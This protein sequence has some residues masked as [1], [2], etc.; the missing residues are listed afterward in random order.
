M[1]CHLAP[2]QVGSVDYEP[3]GG[4]MKVGPQGDQFG[5]FV[6]ANFRD[7]AL[8][9]FDGLA[10]GHWKSARTQPLQAALA[11]MT[12]E[13]RAVVRR[14][15]Q[16]AVDSGLH[17]FL[18]ALGEEYDRGQGIVVLVTGHNVAE[19][20]DGLHGELFGDDGWLVRHSK[21]GGFADP[22]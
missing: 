7:R 8:D 18:F 5:A 13:Q 10:R 3:A 16:A 4:V 17:D 19:Q 22:A 14:C 6:V 2:P 12:P 11:R 20:S 1:Y 21:H 15:V 9:F